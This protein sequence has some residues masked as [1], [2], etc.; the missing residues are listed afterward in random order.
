MYIHS[1]ARIIIII[2]LAIPTRKCQYLSK[3]K[4][5]FVHIT[6]VQVGSTASYSCQKGYVIKGVSYLTCQQ[7]GYWSSKPPVCVYQSYYDDD[8]QYDGG[9]GQYDDGDQ[10]EDY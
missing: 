5:G 6:G 4:Y 9:D 2:I 3:P 10:Y 8:D 7:N 1:W